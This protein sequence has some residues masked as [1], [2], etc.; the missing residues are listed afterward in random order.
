[1]KAVISAAPA[2]ALLPIPTRP[3]GRTFPRGR[4]SSDT[5]VLSVVLVNYLYWD[6]TARLV[7]RLRQAHSMRR[8][9]S[10]V[11][12][13]DN[14][15]PSHPFLGRLRRTEGVSVRRWGRN[16]GFARAVNEGVRLSRGS[17]VL[18]LNPDTTVPGDFLD[19]VTAL[20]DRLDRDEP[21]TGIV[22][23]GL[24]NSDGSPQPSTGP[25]P[26]LLGTLARLLLPRAWRKYHLLSPASGE[27]VPWVTGCALLV[28]R[29]VLEEVGGLDPDF[30][31]YYEDVDLCRRVCD[32]G[33]SVRYEAF[34]EVVHHRP[35]HLRR[36]P[37]HLRF[38]T[39]HALLTYAVKHWPDWQMRFLARIVQFE[40]WLKGRIARRRN[41]KFATEVFEELGR[42]AVEM[43]TGRV[44]AGRRRLEDVVQHIGA[45]LR[46]VAER[47]PSP[48]VRQPRLSR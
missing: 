37:P 41:D 26:S 45:A 35:L 48:R 18:L 20:A 16:R 10:E 42:L 25:F 38:L 33:W 36:M 34:P 13:V 27:K 40:A 19:A 9:A 5:P 39:R 32:K 14:H 6:D 12:I 29:Q 47:I 46:T 1:M 11:V 3:R 8:G 21:G 4:S 7:D 30:F 17:W 2:P 44:D 22:G 28:R 43:R 24:R 15:S 23:L 31:L